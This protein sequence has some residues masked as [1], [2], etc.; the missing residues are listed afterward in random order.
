MITNEVSLKFI[1]ENIGYEKYIFRMCVRVENIIDFEYIFIYLVFIFYMSW[2]FIQKHLFD[3]SVNRVILQYCFELVQGGGD[4][5][6]L[7]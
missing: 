6:V 2:K 5:I 4:G 3:A 7:L 1:E